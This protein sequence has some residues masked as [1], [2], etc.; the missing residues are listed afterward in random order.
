MYLH[1][2]V[3]VRLRVEHRP[4]ARGRQFT[5]ALACAQLDREWVGM[6]AL[7]GALAAL[8]ELAPLA[9]AAELP[10]LGDLRGWLGDGARVAGAAGTCAHRCA[11]RGALPG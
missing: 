8:C 5:H 7:P 10:W 2:L 4:L 3:C 6:R 9:P 11:V 1:V